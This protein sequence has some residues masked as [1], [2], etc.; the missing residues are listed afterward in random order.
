MVW[1]IENGIYAYN[2]RTWILDLATSK[3]ILAILAIVPETKPMPVLRKKSVV[4][5]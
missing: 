3:G 4:G 1:I 5:F 2:I